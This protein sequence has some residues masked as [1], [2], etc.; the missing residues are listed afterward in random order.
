MKIS[1]KKHNIIKYL[2]TSIE[3]SIWE[4]SVSSISF[5]T[6]TSQEDVQTPF[7][8][9]IINEF[10]L[11]YIINGKGFFSSIDCPEE[12]LSK[13][14]IFFIYPDQWNHY[15]PDTETGW[16][17]YSVTFHG[18]YVEKLLNHIFSRKAPVFHIGIK[19]HIVQHLEEMLDCAIAQQAGFQAI[20]SG[21]L[22]H[23]ISLI[24]SINKNPENVPTNMQKIQEACIF[25][26][27]NIYTSFTLEELAHSMNM[28]YSNFRKSFKQCMGLSPHQYLLQLKLNEIKNLLSN[29]TLSI[30]DIAFKLNF[31]S[32]D[33]FSYFFKS[34]TNISPLAYRKEAQKRQGE[35]GKG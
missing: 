13:G 28:S 3:E 23:V 34:K 18:E 21:L 16:E 26:R 19:E 6:Y 32:P 7:Q 10:A 33:Y 24:Y 17:I 25:L 27:N 15:Y 2:H 30:H 29:T 35:K 20:L 14:D 31:E 9:K 22:L 12:N 4:I 1:H 8:G 5:H 11:I